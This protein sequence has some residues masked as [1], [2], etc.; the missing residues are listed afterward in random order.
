[1]QKL[2]QLPKTTKLLA[3]TL[4]AADYLV[5]GTLIGIAYVKI[6]DELGLPMLIATTLGG[7]IEHDVR[8]NCI[9]QTQNNYWTLW[10]IADIRVHEQITLNLNLYGLI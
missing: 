9:L 5:E 8:P 3:N 1:M 6:H 7:C 10:A 4:V 2:I